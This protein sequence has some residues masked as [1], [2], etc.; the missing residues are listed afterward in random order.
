[1]VRCSEYVAFVQANRASR[2]LIEEPS[3]LTI[4]EFKGR[5]TGIGHDIAAGAHQHV[6]SERRFYAAHVGA[7]LR[8]A[9]LR[10]RI[11]SDSNSTYIELLRR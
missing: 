3:F 10:G 9:K 5:S 8:H 4:A 11:A 7:V 2:Q 1:M 6:D